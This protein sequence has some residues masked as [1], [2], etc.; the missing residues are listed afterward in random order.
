MEP[1]TVVLPGHGQVQIIEE[2]SADGRVSH[3]RLLTA[4][5]ERGAVPDDVLC[6]IHQLRQALEFG[7]CGNMLYSGESL[8]DDAA[9]LDLDLSPLVRPVMKGEQHGCPLVVDVLSDWRTREP[10]LVPL[11]VAAAN[12]NE[13]R[14]RV[15]RTRAQGVQW[16]RYGSVFL[17]D[18]DGRDV[19]KVD[20]DH[21]L[22]LD[23]AP[24]R[25]TIGW[26]LLT[27]CA[28]YR[29]R[30]PAAAA[31]DAAR[32]DRL[33][34]EVREIA[35]I[36]ALEHVFWELTRGPLR[37]GFSATWDG[38]LAYTSDTYLSVAPTIWRAAQ[39]ER[40]IEDA[41]VPVYAF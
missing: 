12:A 4:D 15:L 17:L 32:L 29:E 40:G 36:G 16:Q 23:R 20:G 21:D 7:I 1:T 26:L 24:L 22:I 33:T 35:S 11:W 2:R 6:Q 30:K 37:R 38:G 8:R 18:S 41:P 28:T 10:Q 31:L 39:R 19:G 3:Y 5:G 14:R 25:D 27:T 9:R 13:G 34:S